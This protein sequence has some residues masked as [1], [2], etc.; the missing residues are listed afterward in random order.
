MGEA[1]TV[2]RYC[3]VAKKR[4]IGEEELLRLRARMAETGFKAKKP[5]SDD[6]DGEQEPSDPKKA[7]A[8]E[9]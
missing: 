6:V 1:E 9:F 4:E 2:R 5:A 8:G 3:G 7:P